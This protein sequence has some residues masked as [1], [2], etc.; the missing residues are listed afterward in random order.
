MQHDMVLDLAEQLCINYN[1][2]LFTYALLY[3]LHI[4]FI[5]S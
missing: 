5:T 1:Y 4:L 2:L 3:S